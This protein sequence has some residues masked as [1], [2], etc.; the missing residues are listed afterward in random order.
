VAGWP[1]TSFVPSGAAQ[2]LAEIEAGAMP[3]G[4]HHFYSK[5]YQ[6]AGYEDVAKDIQRPWLTGA[7]AEA[8]ALVP[9]DLVLPTSFLGAQQMVRGHIRACRDAGAAS[10]R[11]YP[12]GRSLHGRPDTLDRALD[13]VRSVDSEPA[14]AAARLRAQ[15]AAGAD[16]GQNGETARPS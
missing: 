2:V 5:A 3:A 16:T 1:G 12:E 15:L 4:R 14:N 10:L 7:G 8:A 13:L 11:R 6:R 9:D